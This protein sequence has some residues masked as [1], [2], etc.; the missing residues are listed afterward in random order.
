MCH[1]EIESFLHE[2]GSRPELAPL[3]EGISSPGEFLIQEI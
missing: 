2:L 3:R 1:E